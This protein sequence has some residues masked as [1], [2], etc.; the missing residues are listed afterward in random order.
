MKTKAYCYLEAPQ[1]D[2]KGLLSAIRFEWSL[3]PPDSKYPATG[4]C[5]FD[6]QL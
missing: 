3:P 4:G 6:V 5:F 2:L 1:L